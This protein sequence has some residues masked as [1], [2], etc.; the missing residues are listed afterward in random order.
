M[1][2]LLS[3]SKTNKSSPTGFA[4][5][6]N[7][8]YQLGPTPSTSTGYTL[9]T[10]Q[11]SMATFASSLGNL[12]FNSGTV[13][14][15]IPNQNIQFIGTG[16]GTV[17]VSGPQL[18]T[19]TSTGALVVNGGIGIANGLYTG[20]DIF[21]N[22]LRIGQGYE[23]F[24]NVVVR[25]TFTE[26]GQNAPDGE[27]N[28]AIGYNTLQNID[29][30]LNS[31]AIGN[32]ALS[33]G[34]YTVNTIALGVD[35]LKI[36]GTIA[37]IFVGDITDVSS[38]LPTLVTVPG[39]GLTTGTEILIT[40]VG[41]VTALNDQY[42]LVD[43]ISSDILELYS[44]YD[45]NLKNPISTAQFYT[46]GGSVYKA[47]V[48]ENNIGVGTAAGANFYQG[49]DNL[50]LGHN[51]AVN[52]ASGSYNTL[53]G[54]DAAGNLTNGNFNIS[55]DGT[56]LVDGVDSQVSIGSMF[57]YNGDGYLQLDTNV[58]VG[59]GDDAVNTTS[60][61]A[62]IVYGGVGIS[63]SLFVGSNLH[64]EGYGVVKLNPT[65]GG[66]QIEPHSGGTV[67]IYPESDFP[68]NMDNVYIGSYQPRDGG[69]ENVRASTVSISS[70]QTSSSPSTGALH[71]AGGVGINGNLYIGGLS[72]A[73]TE[74]SLYYNT[75]TNE[76]TYGFIGLGNSTHTD[77]AS[78]ATDAYHIIVEPV[79]TSTLYYPTLIDSIGQ[80][81]PLDVDSNLTYDT[82]TDTLTV[83]TEKIT[84]TAPSTS[85]VTGA[86]TVSGGVGVN[87]SIYSAD[88]NPQMNHLLYTP[89]INVNSTPP[90]NPRPGDVWVDLN[91]FAYYQWINDNGN[92]F[93]L[94]ITIL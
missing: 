39:H 41:G 88:G 48:T 49:V 64:V 21:V 3:G 57:Y 11:N 23:G 90:L 74:Y 34:T 85:T 75:A 82:A 50:F 28:I 19:S 24:N 40:G 91:N 70:T 13:Y 51:A 80:F 22:G 4:N 10:D 31:I 37:N 42:F 86:L 8:Q 73:Q 69:F 84:S 35:S 65:G 52:F 79:S 55:I 44:I 59:L 46:G 66:V 6:T 89:Q 9:F 15:N 81:R 7:V 20:D 30:S 26:G 93:W 16:T 58:G 78:T 38:A 36:A 61:G 63:K 62:L 32:N 27:G 67:T 94:Q 45:P 87:G 29:K 25:G 92:Q 2:N 53:I 68:G 72:D 1:P 71:V 76:I 5:L 17:I 77:T 43:I 18:N 60:T 47:W 83:P 14:S 33:T 12:E 54:H 56:R